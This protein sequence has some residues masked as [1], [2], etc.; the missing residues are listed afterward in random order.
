[1][2][3]EIISE[4]DNAASE[5]MS[6][7]EQSNYVAVNKKIVS[8]RFK[9]LRNKTVLDLGCGY[10]WYANYFSSIG[11]I[12]TG[13]DGSSEMIALARKNYPDIAFE[14]VDIQQVFPYTDRS[15]DLV[16]CNQ[17]LMDIENLDIVIK[18][19]HRV[20]KQDGIF[21]FAIVHPAFY[22][23]EWVRDENGFGKSKIMSRYLSNYS[24]QNEFWG[25]TIH[26]H[27]PIS[28]YFN[29]VIKQGFVLTDIQEP[30]TYDGISKS[31]EL[32]LFLFAE[33]VK[34]I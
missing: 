11:S 16:F 22:S 3:N 25:K 27:R 28:S 33:F 4:W 1:M 14:I 5:Y 23:G 29:S 32:P 17:V 9:D 7:Q 10:G 12:V 15:F 8:D 2:S 21:Y 20:L 19:A 6:A 34:K 30:V 18:E 26:F 31:K 13:C 24:F